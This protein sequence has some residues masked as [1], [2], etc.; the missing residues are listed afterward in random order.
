MELAPGHPVATAQ[1]VIE[2]MFQSLFLWNSRPDSASA[3]GASHADK[4][5][6]LV[7]VEL[8]PGLKVA[9]SEAVLPVKVSILVFVE[10]APGRQHRQQLQYQSLVSILVFVELAPGRPNSTGPTERVSCFNPCFCGT[11]AR[12]LPLPHCS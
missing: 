10:L 11:R 5:S 7:F 9:L 8:A 12:T 6:I 1:E 4:V 3:S 2:A